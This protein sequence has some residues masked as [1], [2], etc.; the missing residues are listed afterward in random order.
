MLKI[1]FDALGRFST[2]LYKGNDFCDFRFVFLRN[3][4]SEKRSTLKGKKKFSSKD[5]T[6]INFDYF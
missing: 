4:L 5:S 3:P 1:R 2:I 6:F